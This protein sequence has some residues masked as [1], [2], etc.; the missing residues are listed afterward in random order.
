MT[1]IIITDRYEGEGYENVCID[2]LHDGKVVGSANAMV[3]DTAYLERIDIDEE[4]RNR[5]IGTE[6]LRLI[7]DE[8][9]SIYLAPDNEDAARLYARI[10]WEYTGE[11]AEYIDQGYGVYEIR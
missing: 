4:Y 6:A 7:A 2:I 1:E 9:D 8:L 5:G 11:D 10:G 3:S